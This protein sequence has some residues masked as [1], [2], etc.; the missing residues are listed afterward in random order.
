[1]KTR[2][3]KVN[4]KSRIVVFTYLETMRWCAWVTRVKDLNCHSVKC[5]F[6]P[7]IT[8]VTYKIRLHFGGHS[9]FGCAYY[10]LKCQIHWSATTLKPLTVQNEWAAVYSAILCRET[11]DPLAQTVR[12][13]TCLRN[14]AK[15]WRDPPGLKMPRIQILLNYT[16]YWIVL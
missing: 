5:R 7:G 10:L 15:S 12:P 3:R 13:N 4:R 2:R 6:L 8:W 9:V 16:G 11:L 14:M 1:M